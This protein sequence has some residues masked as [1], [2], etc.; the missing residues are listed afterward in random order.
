MYTYTCILCNHTTTFYINLENKVVCVKTCNF[1]K[2]IIFIYID[3]E[4]QTTLTQIQMRLCL[5]LNKHFCDTSFPF[6]KR[7]GAILIPTRVI[8][9]SHTIRRRSTCVLTLTSSPAW[10]TTVAVRIVSIT[11]ATN[12]LQPNT[13]PY[14]F[15][16]RFLAICALGEDAIVTT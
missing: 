2:L 10:S 3:D 7:N 13:N 8:I 5:S 11:R 15:L 12:V 14:R 4:K 9:S 16:D 1:W 6:Q